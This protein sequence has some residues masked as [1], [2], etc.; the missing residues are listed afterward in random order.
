MIN[1]YLDMASSTTPGR[2]RQGRTSTWTDLK[3]DFG[4]GFRFHGP[5]STPLRVELAKSRESRILRLHLVGPLSRVTSCSHHSL[6]HARRLAILA[7][8]GAV[9]M[10]A[11]GASTQSPRF[12]PDD[13]IAREPESQDA[14]KAAPFDQSQMYELLYNLFVT[15]GTQPS[16]LRAKNI[17]TIDEVPDSSWFTNRIGTQDDDDRGARARP[18]CRRSRPTRR[19][20][21]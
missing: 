17:N 12:F 7:A 15:S 4:I 2:W 5:F 6:R 16:G 8:V 1:R 10:F 13:P 9:A 19:S 11:A 20:G 21:C 14:S 18:E 3:D